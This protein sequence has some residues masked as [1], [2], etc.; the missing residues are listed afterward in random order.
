M[1][2]P[3]DSNSDEDDIAA[4]VNLNNEFFY[5][6][7]FDEYDT[8]SDDDADLVVVVATSSM[9]K[10]RPPC[11]NGGAPC[12]GEPPIWTTIG[13]PATC[14][15]MPTTSTRKRRCTEAIFGT[16]F[17]CQGSF[18]GELLKVFAFTTHI[19]DVSRMPQ[20]NLASLHIRNARLLY[21]C[22]LME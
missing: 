7:F 19:A 6:H 10:T 20:V 11:L 13:R 18:L 22:L 17:G 9:R 16:V 4:I 21:E 14:S 15:F 1:S 2:T 5:T 3:R 12:R 8:D